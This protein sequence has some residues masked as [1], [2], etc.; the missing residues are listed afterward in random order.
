MAKATAETDEKD[1][2]MEDILQ[3]IKQ[4]I[5]DEG[6]APPPPA[7]APAPASAAPVGEDILELTDLIQEDGSV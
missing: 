1:P 5:A 7:A 4:I 6:D 2:S 3:S